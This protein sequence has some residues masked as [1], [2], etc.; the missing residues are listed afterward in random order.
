[1]QEIDVAE[2]SKFIKAR[3]GD[4]NNPNKPAERTGFVYCHVIDGKCEAM[5][6]VNLPIGDQLMVATALKET[7]EQIIQ[8][9]MNEVRK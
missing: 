1:M 9:I 7:A 8:Q 3:V 2:I 6:L 5:T 4:V